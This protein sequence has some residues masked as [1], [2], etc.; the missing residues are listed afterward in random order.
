M[1]VLIGCEFSGIVRDSFLAQGHNAVSCDLLPSESPGPHLQ[2]D[3]ANY[4]LP[5][6][7]WDMLFAFPPCTY[8]S[9]S[10]ARYWAKRQKEQRAALD[11]VTM[12]MGADIHRIAIE[13]P[14]GKISTAIRRPDQIIQPYEYG[15][16]ETKQTCLWLK[17][18]PILCPTNIVSGRETR[19]LNEAPGPDRWKRRSRT[20]QGIADAMA[21]QWGK[22]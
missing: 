9:S 19:I 13:N 20:Y 5:L 17:N 16:G 4:L 18:L 2:G 3:I 22:E 10:G 11:F 6:Y 12:L 14:V 8:L 15:H 1:R 21:Q 7:Q